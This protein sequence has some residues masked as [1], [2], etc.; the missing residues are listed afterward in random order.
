MGPANADAE[1][2][3]WREQ[4]KGVKHTTALVL[5]ARLCLP[6]P[7]SLRAASSTLLLKAK[8]KGGGVSGVVKLALERDLFQEC[9]TCAF[10][11]FMHS[12]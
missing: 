2:A 1:L 11:F 9:C 4:G 8:R 7:C 3:A 12:P 6:Y 10:F 5:V